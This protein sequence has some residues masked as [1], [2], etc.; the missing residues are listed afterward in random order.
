MDST[1]AGRGFSRAG[2]RDFIRP[3]PHLSQQGTSRIIDHL[4]PASEEEIAGDDGLSHH[5]DPE[6]EGVDDEEPE[7]EV[8]EEGSPED[9]R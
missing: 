8:L 7:V 6:V 4:N 3:T 5:G 2:L 1:E 9:G